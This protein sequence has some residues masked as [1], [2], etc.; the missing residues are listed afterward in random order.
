MLRPCSIIAVILLA[1]SAAIGCTGDEPLVVRS[2]D[3]P[4]WPNLECDPLVPSHCGL[5]FPSNVFTASD[6]ASATGRRV[7]LMPGTL[8]TASSGNRVKPDPWR[9]SDGFSPGIALL[10]HFPGL[11]PSGLP[12]PSTIAS[13]LGA[14][15]PTVLLDAET[16]ERIPHFAELDLSGDNDAE[17][18]LMIR[19]VVRLADARRY[20]V[21]IRDI[22][23]ESGPITASPA[24][25]ALRDGTPSSEPSIEARRGLYAEIFRRLAAA[26]V[27]KGNLVLAWDFTTASRESNTA[28]M[29]HMRDEALALVGADGPSYVI[30]SV[31]TDYEPAQIAFRL[32]GRMTVPL[33]LD[34]P[35]AGANLVF[36]SDGLPEPNASRPT[37]EVPFEVLIPQSATAAP[38]ALLEYGHGLLGSRDEI[39]S[40][41]VRGFL[42]QYNYVGF[43]V[44]LSGFS[45]ED[46][47]HIIE[48]ISSGQLDR[49]STMFDRMHQGTL[50]FLLAMRMMSRRFA[51]DPSYGRYVSPEERYYYGISQGGIFGG[52]YMALSTDVRRGAL[53]VMG[54]P[55]NLLLNRSVDFA[56]FFALLNGAFPNSLDQQ[57]GL[58]LIQMLWD[59]VEPNGY[60]PY[61]RSNLLPGTPSHEVLMTAAVGDHQVTTLGGQLMARSVGAQH[62]DTGI[63]DVYGLT[64]VADRVTGSA[65]VEYDFGL[66]PEPLCNVPMTACGDPHGKLRRQVP[67][68]Q[69]IDQFLRTGEIANHCDDG[70][71]KFPALSECAPGATTPPCGAAGY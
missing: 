36:G 55:Y 70:S 51:A 32:N 57:F 59:R 60:T 34:Q 11:R 31:E 63:R 21:A 46:L 67:A 18:A 66:P 37:Y 47:G 4:E 33:Y 19:P 26:G 69:Q 15:S 7:A 44:D 65:Y 43:A 39:E 20:I 8:P 17:R 1:G 61:I 68:Q 45:G 25:E 2:A 49:L 71:C 3:S 24:F 40:G 54:Q 13:S 56:P 30:D 58:D 5:P 9:K 27:E 42:N 14:T 52:V 22:E 62:L 6:A 38:A 41:V 53:D 64:K 12:T 35:E 16:G 10:A 29:V 28:W 48:V 23:G 50:N